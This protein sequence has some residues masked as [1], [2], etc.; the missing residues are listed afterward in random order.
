MNENHKER[1][2]GIIATIV[3]VLIVGT[4]AIV[5]VTN[6]MKLN[7]NIYCTKNATIEFRD[8]A[9]DEKGQ[10]LGRQE[11]DSPTPL[12]RD[13]NADIFIYAKKNVVDYGSGCKEFSDLSFGAKWNRILESIGLRER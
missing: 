13:A 8:N 1:R 2:E 11:N 4:L 3:I 12:L 9:V 10:V 6:L 5:V 7:Q